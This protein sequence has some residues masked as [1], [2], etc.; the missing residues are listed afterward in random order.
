MNQDNF[1]KNIISKDYNV[2]KNALTELINS[3]NPT[4]FK[5]LCDNSDF[6]FPFVKEKIVKNFVTL[7]KKDNLDT[8]FLFTIAGILK[9]LSYKAG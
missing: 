1:V 9:I 5:K 6:I 8:V 7:I 2:S 3:K 4:L